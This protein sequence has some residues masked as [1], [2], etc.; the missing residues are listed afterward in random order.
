MFSVLLFPRK[1]KNKTTVVGTRD[2]VVVLDYGNKACLGPHYDFFNFECN[3]IA[4]N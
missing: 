3:K 2:L 4:M 1:L